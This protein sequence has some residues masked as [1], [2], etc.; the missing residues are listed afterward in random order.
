MVTRAGH[1][2]HEFSSL[3]SFSEQ[4]LVIV[5]ANARGLL[6]LRG[7]NVAVHK[8][9]TASS[10]AGEIFQRRPKSANSP[11]APGDQRCMR[12]VETWRIGCKM[13]H[14]AWQA[15]AEMPF[16]ECHDPVTHHASF[17]SHLNSLSTTAGSSCRRWL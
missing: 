7:W 10:F 14:S 15:I 1:L 5:S 13:H 16:S 4:C 3:S 6:C 17:Q 9:S 2:C 12:A 8:T 11:M